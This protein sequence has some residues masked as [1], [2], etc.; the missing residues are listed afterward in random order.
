[1]FAK[2][3]LKW[4]EW[5]GETGLR[6]LDRPVLLI[7]GEKDPIS[8]P[9]DIAALQQAAV[10]EARTLQVPGA[11]HFVVGMCFNELSEPITAWFRQRL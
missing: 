7:G 1:M 11:D 8:R 10:G 6:R 4:K 3:E 5:A 9:A 2:L